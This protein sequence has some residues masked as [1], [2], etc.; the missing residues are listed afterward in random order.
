MLI[1]TLL[2]P[3]IMGCGPRSKCGDR[4]ANDP[5]PC[6]GPE[7]TVNRNPDVDEYPQ[8][9]HED[10]PTHAPLQYQAPAPGESIHASQT[11][12]TFSITNQNNAP[13][14]QDIARLDG[15]PLQPLE[16]QQF[17]SRFV[18]DASLDEGVELESGLH[19]LEFDDGLGTSINHIFRQDERL[20]LAGIRFEA[21]T[22]ST[23]VTKVHVHFS[24]RVTFSQGSDLCLDDACLDADQTLTPSSVFTLYIPKVPAESLTLA[25]SGA[26][27][28]E[29]PLSVLEWQQS[30]P[31]YTGIEADGD[32]ILVSFERGLHRKP[33]AQGQ[34]CWGIAPTYE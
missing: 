7:E 8:S 22:S 28:G 26:R 2:M 9:M 11:V 27:D 25:I 10:Q 33:C 14:I 5:I 3:H 32:T 21:E 30:S 16:T 13:R 24:R 31:Y 6:T 4:S 15:N 17:G 18:I 1:L 23:Q 29:Q 19:T 12:F 34:R 20:H